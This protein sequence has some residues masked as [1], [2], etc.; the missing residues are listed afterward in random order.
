MT[1][2]GGIL[3]GVEK[4]ET[5][6]VAIGEEVL[7]GVEKGVSPNP[8]LRIMVAGNNWAT[9]YVGREHIEALIAALE[10]AKR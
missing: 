7:L 9:V 4:S 8:S 10:W 2:I 1:P 6:Y 5:R 3:G